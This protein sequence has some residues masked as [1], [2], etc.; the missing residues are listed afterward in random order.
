M[1]GFLFATVAAFATPQLEVAPVFSDH[2]VLQRD[3]PVVLW[4]PAAAGAEV[5]VAWKGLRVSSNADD[6]GAWRLVMPALPANAD[7]QT[8]R[9]HSGEQTVELN[10]ILTGDVWICAGQSNMDS[11]L[12]AIAMQWRHGNRPNNLR[13]GFLMPNTPRQVLVAHRSRRRESCGR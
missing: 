8:F 4:G 11:H 2:M 1:L 9:L 13:F 10:D 12:H 7:G 6:S 5:V 3:Q